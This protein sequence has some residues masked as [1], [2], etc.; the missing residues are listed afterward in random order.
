MTK[1]YE[2]RY[3]LCYCVRF[4]ASFVLVVVLYLTCL[5]Y[6]LMCNSLCFAAL[7]LFLNK[8]IFV[9]NEEFFFMITLIQVCCDDGRD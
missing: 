6:A 8:V 3:S 4:Y 2:F 1:V 9:L 7:S 5:F